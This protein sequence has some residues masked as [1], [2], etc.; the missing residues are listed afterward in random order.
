M[1][2]ELIAK[3][4]R[5]PGSPRAT[6]NAQTADRARLVSSPTGRKAKARGG[7]RPTGVVD[8]RIILGQNEDP[9][10]RAVVYF[11]ESIIT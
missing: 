2:R 6:A 7:G 11:G 9:E 1:S 4:L 3:E 10:C 5:V 8:P